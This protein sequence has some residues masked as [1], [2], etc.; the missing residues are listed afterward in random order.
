[1]IAMNHPLLSRDGQKSQRLGVAGRKGS[2]ETRIKLFK[3]LYHPTRITLRRIEGHAVV[4]RQLRGRCTKIS[5]R[6][7]GRAPT[8]KKRIE[9]LIA[10]KHELFGDK[11]Q[12][13]T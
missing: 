2:K 12:G 13:N 11:V 1:M 7:Q 10:H 9:P 3:E 5:G 4:T 8:I 6:H